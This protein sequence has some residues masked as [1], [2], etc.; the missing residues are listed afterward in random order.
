MQRFSVSTSP[1]LALSNK[2]TY[3]ILTVFVLA[4][5]AMRFYLAKTQP[6]WLDETFTWGEL[7][8]S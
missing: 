4:G 5:L 2:V 8:H 3:C 1:S 7:R 6:F